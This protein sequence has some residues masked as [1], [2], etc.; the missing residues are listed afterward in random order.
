MKAVPNPSQPTKNYEYTQKYMIL[1]DERDLEE[2]LDRADEDN[3]S[4][5]E[6]KRP[7]KRRRGGELGRDWKCEV[8][9]CEKD[10]KSKKAMITHHKV[11]HLGRRDF[12]CDH[13]GCGSDFGYKHLLQRHLAK[14]HSSQF[15]P[16]NTGSEDG[17]DEH[18]EMPG[19]T[20]QLVQRMD[21]D[22]ITGKT[23]DSAAVERLASS[24]A[25]RCPHPH[26]PFVAGDV[27]TAPTA[28]SHAP[29][30]YVFSRGYDLR[31]H[32]LKE[33]G[34]DAGKDSVNAWV[35]QAKADIRRA[36]PVT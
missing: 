24:K 5:G 26:L 29:C 36:Q 7:R 22:F 16:D 19:K 25:L 15:N 11:T 12:A 9:G 6:D 27:Q 35:M 20:K 31:R 30:P 17:D 14:V 33:H 13:P 28:E 21:I 2:Q 4:E 18:E 32:L 1:H 10:F 3:E 34:V 23:Y 8:A